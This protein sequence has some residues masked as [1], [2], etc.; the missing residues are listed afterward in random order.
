VTTTLTVASVG[1]TSI[2]YD[3][4]LETTAGVAV[5]GP[6]VTVLVDPASARPDPVPD[7][8]RTALT[9]G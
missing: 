7:A 2:S 4:R 8:L 6:I 5:T 3:V 1:R 9:A